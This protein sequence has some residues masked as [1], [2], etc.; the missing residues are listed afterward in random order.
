LM[1]AGRAVGPG[2]WAGRCRRGLA[3]PAIT[4]RPEILGA[5]PGD[6]LRP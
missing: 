1:P 3:W 2:A 5:C 4:S 6:C